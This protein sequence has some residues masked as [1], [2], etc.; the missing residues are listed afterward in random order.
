MGIYVHYPVCLQKCHYCDFYSLP[1]NAAGLHDED[2]VNRI[3]A[4]FNGRYAQFA[5][6]TEVDSIFFGGGTPS[7]LRPSSVAS[8][9][10]VFRSRFTITQDCEISLEANP[11]GLSPTYL[12]ELL[13]AG[14]NRLNVGVQSFSR[15]ALQ[16][17]HRHHEVAQYAEI[18]PLLEDSPIR[19]R[20]LDLIFGLP[21]QDFEADL[22]RALAASIE[23]LSLYSLTVEAGTPYAS[24]IGRGDL[25]A[26]DESEQTDWLLRLP[27]MLEPH[28]YYRYEISNFAR[29]GF[30]CRHNLRYWLY[31]PYMGLGPAAHGFNGARRYA[32][33]KDLA[34]WLRHPE[35]GEAEDHVPWIDVPLNLFRLTVPFP[36]GW[37]ADILGDGARSIV[38][39]FLLAQASLGRGTF[40][41]RELFQWNDTGLLFLDSI[42][43]EWLQI[44]P[45]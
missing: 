42:L 34:R 10:D 17:V 25:Q 30:Q 43:D 28:G 4:E 21:G 13:R 6:F 33:P 31:E 45:E 14:V 40:L 27:G 26:P 22:D 38:R 23:H 2:F 16:A 15:P 41:D 5:G 11:D 32:N 24:R 29:P 1:R 12:M 39:D 7:L 9:I 18:L 37:L 3:T 35:A 44:I 19:N 8:I 36:H 20:G